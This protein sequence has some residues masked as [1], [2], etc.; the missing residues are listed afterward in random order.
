VTDLEAK[1]HTALVLSDDIDPENGISALRLFATEPTIPPN[2][3]HFSN[4]NANISSGNS[5]W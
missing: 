2:T 5:S 4:P 1:C 3:P